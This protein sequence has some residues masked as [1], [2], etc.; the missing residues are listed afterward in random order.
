MRRPDGSSPGPLTA[1]YPVGAA[2]LDFPF[3]AVTWGG[4]STAVSTTLRRYEAD[5][6]HRL[7]G[8][9]RSK[10]TG[11][12]LRQPSCGRFSQKLIGVTSEVPPC[13]AANLPTA[14]AIASARDSFR[15]AQAPAHI[16]I[17]IDDSGPMQPYLQQITAAVDAEL[18]PDAA[19]IGSD[20]SFGIWK[21]PGDRKGQ[22]DRRLVSFGAAGE[23]KARVPAEVGALTGHDHSADY[24]MLTQAGQL[25]YEQRATDPEPS[26]SVILLTDGDGYPGVDPGGSSEESVTGNFDSPPPG[27][28]K[29]RLYI[30]AFGPEGCAESWTNSASQS[31]ATFA[32]ATGGTCWQSNGA[33]PTQLL[34][35]VLSQVSTGG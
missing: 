15:T 2:A 28:R 8:R 27:H 23:A 6:Y 10:L 33:N 19:H 14:Q 31:L 20:D 24:A 35:E 7:T 17:G 25:L 3:T 32:D 21:L 34:A 5:F 22:L 13:G 18:G 12:G 16:L 26:N 4:R 9:S 11:A 29:I 1:F 30:I